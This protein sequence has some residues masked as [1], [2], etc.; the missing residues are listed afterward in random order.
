MNYLDELASQIRSA[1]PP[2]Q[3]PDDDTRDLFRLYALLMLAKGG[4]VDAVDVHN[5]W[6]VWMATREPNHESLI[7]FED[8]PAKVAAQDTPYVAA[9][10]QVAGNQGGAAL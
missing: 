4:Q 5:A 7:P 2:S 6:V 1:V 3:L 10:R 9:I 8:L